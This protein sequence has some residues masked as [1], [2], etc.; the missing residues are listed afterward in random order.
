M[1]TDGA[2]CRLYREKKQIF[3]SENP[4]VCPIPMFS[5]ED[6]CFWFYHIRYS[7]IP[8]LNSIEFHPNLQHAVSKHVISSHLKHHAFLRK[9][10]D[11][12]IIANAKKINSQRR[13]IFG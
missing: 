5:G 8:P 11:K 9:K 6:K 4:H 12:V 1:R 13:N 3:S 2:G 10:T 7:P